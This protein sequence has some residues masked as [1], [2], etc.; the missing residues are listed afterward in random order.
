VLF[1]LERFLWETR[2]GQRSNELDARDYVVFILGSALCEGVGFVVNRIVFAFVDLLLGS[3]WI[4]VYYVKEFDGPLRFIIWVAL[5]YAT[6]VLVVC[7]VHSCGGATN[8]V[9]G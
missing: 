2:L 6:C 5:R 8:H 3:V 9:L 7:C 1:L 4:V